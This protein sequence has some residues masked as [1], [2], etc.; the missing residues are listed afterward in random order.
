[1]NY[2][3]EAETTT[4]AFDIYEHREYAEC[5][6]LDVETVPSSQLKTTD[7]MC[8]YAP[9][10]DSFRVEMFFLNGTKTTFRFHEK[11]YD[12]ALLVETILSVANLTNVLV[13]HDHDCS[14]GCG[15]SG[16]LT[17]INF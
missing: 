17:V 2:L 8:C 16:K 12:R 14:S 5:A 13:W 1:M 6:L 3:D 4:C 15:C 10:D 11:E 9:D 7:F